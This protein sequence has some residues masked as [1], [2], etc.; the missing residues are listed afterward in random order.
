MESLENPM[1]ITSAITLSG[2][3]PFEQLL[4]VIE[5]RFLAN[6]RFRMRIVDSRVPL[7]A[8]RWEQVPHFDVRAHVHHVRLPAPGDEASFDELIS[9][10]MSTRLD[11]ERPLWQTYVVDDV[12]GGRTAI[13][14]RI[15][16][17]L[18]DG[19][20]LVRV[21]LDF[22]DET[23]ATP[24]PS[25]GLKR[26]HRE[27]DLRA[28]SQRAA[29]YAGT[30][31]RLLLLPSDP[32]SPL[33]G[34]LGG[35]KRAT[36]CAPLPLA[37]LKAAA[38]RRG[39]TLNDL[40]SAMVAGALHRFLAEA[41]LDPS[42]MIVRALVPVFL[43]DTDHT[44]LGNHFGL[45]FAELPVGITDPEERLRATKRGL[46]KLKA[47][48]DATVA[49]AVLD[50]VGVGSREL[51]HVWLEVFSRKSSLLLTNVPGPSETLRVAGHSVEDVTVWAPVSG[52]LGVAFSSISYAGQVRVSIHTDAELAVDPRALSRAFS[53]EAACYL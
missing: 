23:C 4:R 8:P 11:P 45:V 43:Q 6:E 47:Q 13:I 5:A 25:V 53:A 31:G 37:Q 26:P 42:G 38:K 15:H 29:A 39:A 32:K 7:A 19:V 2:Q 17:C 14:S 12:P 1:V 27:L 41:G 18:A 28:L 48:D 49:F 20:A 33:R 9:D 16:H 22:A 3:V 46:D 24:P 44:G 21:L 10:L 51:E 50:A 40:L 52:Y 35:R 36:R 30:L 34:P